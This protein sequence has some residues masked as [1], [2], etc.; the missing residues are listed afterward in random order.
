MNAR[1]SA[2]WK[3]FHPRF[4]EEAA[5][6]SLRMQHLIKSENTFNCSFRTDPLS[7]V[8]ASPRST[9]QKV[10]T[11]LSGA[12]LDYVGSSEVASIQTRRVTPVSFSPGKSENTLCVSNSNQRLCSSCTARAQPRRCPEGRTV[13]LNF[14]SPHHLHEQR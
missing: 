13:S 8:A 1:K 6:S 9:K 14:N 4:G 3:S 7:E 10:S 5:V 2:V 12:P 11:R